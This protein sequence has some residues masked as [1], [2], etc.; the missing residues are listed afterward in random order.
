MY[1]SP[2][3]QVIRPFMTT[4]AMIAISVL[5][6]LQVLGLGILALYI[7]TVPT[8]TTKLDSYAI[9]QLTKDMDGNT[10]A[11]IGRDVEGSL[12]KFR[13]IDGL[14]GVVEQ[15]VEKVGPESPHSRYLRRNGSSGSHDMTYSSISD[16]RNSGPP[17]EGQTFFDL[18][19]DLVVATG[20][21]HLARGAAGIITRCHV[22]PAT[23]SDC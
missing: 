5:V 11:A 16:P 15:D 17:G 6:S 14:V 21:Y 18:D 22:P 7:Y 1:T 8:W 9:A 4:G 13:D 20:S 19:S 12:K 10:V 3:S 2:G 23:K